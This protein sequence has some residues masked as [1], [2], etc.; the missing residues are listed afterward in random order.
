MGFLPSL[1]W[2]Y[3]YEEKAYRM[4]LAQIIQSQLTENLTNSIAQSIH[5]NSDMTLW[6]KMI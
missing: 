2:N 3:L 5:L 4:A 1:G 6:I